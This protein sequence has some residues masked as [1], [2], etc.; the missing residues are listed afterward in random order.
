MKNITRALLIVALVAVAGTSIAKADSYR[1][2]HYAYGHN[3][4]WDEHHH[5]RHWDHYNNHD[6]YWTHRDGVRV[7]ID[8]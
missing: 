5:Y 1:D 7:F 2:P 3:G 8:I 6:G 4:Y